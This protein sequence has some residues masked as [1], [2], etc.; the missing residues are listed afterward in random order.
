MRTEQL[1]YFEENLSEL[2]DCYSHY[3]FVWE[4]FSIDQSENLKKHSQKLTTEI[5][6]KIHTADNSM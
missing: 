2:N 6:D 1:K 5:F 4:Q 3:I